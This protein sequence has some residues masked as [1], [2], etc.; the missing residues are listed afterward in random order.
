MKKKD[1]ILLENAYEQTLLNEGM[2]S[3]GIKAV[4]QPLFN[5]LF[6]KIKEK[7]PEAFAKLA[8]VKTPQEL[9]GLI[10]SYKQG[11]GAPQQHSEGIQDV[12]GKVKQ[13]VASLVERLEVVGNIGTIFA[14]L[15]G[16]MALLEYGSSGTPNYGMMVAGLFMTA[17]Q[18]AAN[19]GMDIAGQGTP[20]NRWPM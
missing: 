8:A 4:L 16:I 10:N 13:A 17:I 6:V 2:L 1:Q 9:L 15:G 3:S 14:G 5:N 18:L 12:I 20:R 7:S 11:S 19:V